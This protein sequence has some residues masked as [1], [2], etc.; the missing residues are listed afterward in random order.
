MRLRRCV[1]LP[2]SRILQFELFLEGIY[3]PPSREVAGEAF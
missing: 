2:G 1:E 3:L